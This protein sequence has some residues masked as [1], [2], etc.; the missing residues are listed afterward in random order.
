MV[1]GRVS[2]STC[3]D[4]R[5]TSTASLLNRIARWLTLLEDLG[6]QLEGL[7]GPGSG[8]PAH[9]FDRT[10]IPNSIPTPLPRVDS[11]HV[12]RPCVG[13]NA[14][15]PAPGSSAL[16]FAKR[17][18]FPNDS[19]GFRCFGP[20]KVSFGNRFRGLGIHFRSPESPA[21]TSVASSAAP[22]TVSGTVGTTAGTSGVSSATSGAEPAT[23]PTGSGTAAAGS[24][25]SLAVYSSSEGSPEVPDSAAEV[26]EADVEAAPAASAVHPVASG[27][28][29]GAFGSAPFLVVIVNKLNELISALR[30]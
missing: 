28:P 3:K 7:R 11:K 22:E 26:S 20:S 5:S 6:L 27:V 29:L 23:S 25:T 2:T 19:I 1:S 4:G 14:L 21:G 10:V 24:A 18:R 16:M 12:G 15:E 30:R 13:R 9:S 17:P 8:S